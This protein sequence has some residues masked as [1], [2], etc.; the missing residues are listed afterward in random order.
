MATRTKLIRT[1][2]QGFLMVV[3]VYI[4]CFLVILHSK[5]SQSTEQGTIGVVHNVV[6]E[7]S[8]QK[9]LLSIQAIQKQLKRSIGRIDSEHRIES[10]TDAIFTVI[11]GN[12][13]NPEWIPALSLFQSL[14]ESNTIVANKIA[15]VTHQ[16]N[17]PE[18]ATQAFQQLNVFLF[19]TDPNDNWPELRI[20]E[21]TQFRRILFVDCLSLVLE[22]IDQ[23]F[24]TSIEHN[25]IIS[26][27]V[28]E[29]CYASIPCQKVTKDT[30]SSSFFLVSTQCKSS[31][32]LNGIIQRY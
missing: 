29:E 25:Q 7:I 30:F 10:T 9:R 32:H 2:F 15:I 21:F 16:A 24:D 27:R 4:C 23:V 28:Q 8:L 11:K 14:Y 18:F 12:D 3:L 20:F 1:V 5:N 26:A 17:L 22:N 31:V 6:E 19:Y 13:S